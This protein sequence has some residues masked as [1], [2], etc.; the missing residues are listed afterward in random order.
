M[1]YLMARRKPGMGFGSVTGLTLAD[2]ADMLSHMNKKK[3]GS[4]GKG[5]MMAGVFDQLWDDSDR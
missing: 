4:G 5:D 2:V 3:K 1:G